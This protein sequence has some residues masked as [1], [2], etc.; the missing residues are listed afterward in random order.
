MKKRAAVLG[1]FVAVLGGAWMGSLYWQPEAEV[2]TLRRLVVEQENRVVY[3]GWL[4]GADETAQTL[5][6]IGSAGEYAVEVEKGRVRM[7]AA[8]CPDQLC[9]RQGWTDRAGRP[10]VCL[11]QRVVVYLEDV[12][13]A[14]EGIDIL[15]R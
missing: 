13:P 11:P 8:G 5:R 15:V 3:E 6:F 9:V 12:A 7:L 2:P 4:K 10:I 14:A 1:A